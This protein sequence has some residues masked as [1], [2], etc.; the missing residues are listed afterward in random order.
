MKKSNK[1]VIYTA[2]VTIIVVFS[3]TFAILM[4]LERTDYRNYLQAQYS[5]NMYELM[6]SVQNIRV[7]LSKAAVVGSREQNIIVFDEIFR[8]A[9]NAND[10]LHSLPLSQDTIENTS[11]F[12]SQV[13]DFCYTLG[14]TTSEGTQLQDKDYKNIEDLKNRSVKLEANLNQVSND[15]N[16][17]K[18]R[19][20]E[21]RKKVGGVLARNKEDIS[22]QFKGIQKQVTQYP[23]LIYDGPFSD[24]VVEIEPRINKEKEISKEE[25]E[26]KIRTVI[27]ENKVTKIDLVNKESNTGISTY[28]FEVGVKGRN[29]KS[30]RIVCEVSKKGG[31]ILYL[32]DNRLVES[33]KI[34]RDTAM[35][36][37]EEFLKSI[38]YKEMVPTYAIDY[39]NVATVSYVYKKDD[40]MIYP[41]QIKLKI[42][43]D[44][45]SIVGIE[46]AKYLV[47]HTNNRNIPKAKVSLEEARKK[48]GKRLKIKS[49][50]LAIIP[51]ET[52]K[53]KLCYEF[54]GD[55]NGET[56]IVYVNAHTGYEERIIQIINA[57]NGQ[58]TI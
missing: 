34:K 6:D 21:I 40:I 20:G 28:S 52:N 39:G 36:K 38:G 12:L 29:D 48:V 1:R 31:K 13:G 44:D 5:K 10:R 37:G 18:V 9:T 30:D 14:K 16:E 11:R 43:L 49:S 27:G 22:E 53:E 45:G 24:N 17:G 23:A 50:R 56:F 15:I 55:Y 4:T 32:L 46:S 7:N 3:S 35:K 41:D 2:I 54:T 47:S 58:L 8:H 26:K 33:S 19:W 42:A 51:T 25:A 57:P